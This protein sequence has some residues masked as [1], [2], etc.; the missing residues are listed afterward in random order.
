[1]DLIDSVRLWTFVCVCVCVC[2]W[3]RERERER[4][5]FKLSLF[6][7]P[8]ATSIIAFVRLVAR[9]QCKS[10]PVRFY[11]PHGV[12][13]QLS[14]SVFFVLF[15]VYNENHLTTTVKALWRNWKSRYSI[16]FTTEWKRLSNERKQPN[17]AEAACWI[18]RSGAVQ[19]RFLE[20]IISQ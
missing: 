4:E 9:L 14:Q 15:F 20:L 13:L 11:A 5:V 18:N 17:K 6:L 3:K 10:N 2:V 12:S 8:Y 7:K 16:V 1:M 19:S